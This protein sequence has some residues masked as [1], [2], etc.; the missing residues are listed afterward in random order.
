SCAVYTLVAK[1]LIPIYSGMFLTRKLFFYGVIT[2]LPFLIW[3]HSGTGTPYHIGILFDF[4]QPRYVLNF[5]FLAVF[6]SLLAY[7]VW[8]EVMRILGP[9]VA[10]NYLYIQPLVT[11]IAAYFVLSEPIYPLS[12]LGCALIIG[13]LIMADKLKIK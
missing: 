9:V 13:G 10:N 6:C 5:L 7:I 1:R 8:N 12:Y 4:A 3:Q 2:A 11:M